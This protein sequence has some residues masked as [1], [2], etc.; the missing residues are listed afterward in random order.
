M[1]TEPPSPNE[2]AKTVRQPIEESA[3]FS[4]FADTDTTTSLRAHQV[5][6]YALEHACS[7]TFQN[8]HNE[9]PMPSALPRP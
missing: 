4:N 6:W 8:R 3:I 1:Q 9:V 7:T 2:R 5:C